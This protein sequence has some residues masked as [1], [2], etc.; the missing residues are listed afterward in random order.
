VEKGRGVCRQ[1]PTNAAAHARLPAGRLS[2]RAVYTTS[3]RCPR[4]SVFNPQVLLA[5]VA[6]A[7]SAAGGTAAEFDPSSAAVREAYIGPVTHAKMEAA[8]AGLLAALGPGNCSFCSDGG[9]SGFE[10]GLGSATPIFFLPNVSIIATLGAFSDADLGAPNASVFLNNARLRAL[11]SFAT[12]R[13]FTIGTGG[14]AIDTNSFSL[15][16]TGTL[17]ANGTLVK[18]GAGS[19]VLTGGNVWTKPLYITAGVLEGSSASLQTAIVNTGTVRLISRWTASTQ[20][21][22]PRSVRWRSMARAS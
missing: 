3:P 17:T 21:W 1:S 8:L 12:A 9:G 19:L 11:A 5:A 2:V 22:C 10:L 20:A 13:D 16:L 7:L 6:S 15:T 14:A 18:E 4:R